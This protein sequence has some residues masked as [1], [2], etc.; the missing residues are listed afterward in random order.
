MAHEEPDTGLD[1]AP[2]Q[3]TDTPP[4]FNGTGS[5]AVG[6]RLRAVGEVVLCSGFPTQLGIVVLLNLVGA[7]PIDAAGQLS[8]AYIITL[9]VIDAGLII[10]LVWLLL[11]ARG[12]Q[13]IAILVGDRSKVSEGLLGLALVPVALLLVTMAFSIMTKFAPWLHT[14]PENPFETLLTSPTAAILFGFVAVVAGGLREEIQRAF[15][16]RR[17]EQYLGGPVLGLVVFSTAFGLGH[18]VQGQD[19][20][21]VTG[22]LGALWGVVYIKRRS[23]VAP[24]VCH[25]M[26]NLVEVT[27]AYLGAS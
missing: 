16:L 15:I 5:A 7:T 21:I 19:A 23:I 10:A 18:L 2:S 1:V 14:V 17:F 11:V 8:L 27:I 13:P 6:D 26:F 12:E 25:S 9:S 4:E 20:A 24:F 22:L 3:P